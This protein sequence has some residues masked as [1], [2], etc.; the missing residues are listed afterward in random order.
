MLWYTL[1]SFSPSWFDVVSRIF[2]LVVILQIIR[3][4]V[5]KEES[6]DGVWGQYYI[7]ANTKCYTL[8]EKPFFFLYSDLVKKIST[9]SV[10]ARGRRAF[11]LFWTLLTG[12]LWTFVCTV[13][14]GV[15]IL[16]FI[17]HRDIYFSDSCCI[18]LAAKL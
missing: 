14:Q 7:Q 17:M 10:L 1:K 2:N 11:Y 9:P 4:P 6:E 15:L 16:L 5:D 3:T 12:F 13:F 18:L 8:N